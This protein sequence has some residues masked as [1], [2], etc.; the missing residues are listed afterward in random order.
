MCPDLRRELLMNNEM[1]SGPRSTWHALAA[2]WLLICL[3][4]LPSTITH[5]YAADLPE[6]QVKWMV[7]FLEKTSFDAVGLDEGYG[8]LVLWEQAVP[9]KLHFSVGE[10][11]VAD[12]E[13]REWAEE[14]VWRV[15]RAIGSDGAIKLVGTPYT[16][17]AD[18]LIIST[19]KMEYL[20]SVDLHQYLKERFEL[21]KAKIELVLEKME[22]VHY[23]ELSNW[24]LAAFDKGVSGHKKLKGFIGVIHPDKGIFKSTFSRVFAISLGY[25]SGSVVKLKKEISLKSVHTYTDT[26]YV[27]GA[28]EILLRFLYNS[29][30]RSGM[31]REIVVEAFRKWIL[32]DYFKTHFEVKTRGSPK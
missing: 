18:I 4:V 10:A 1:K 17:E 20:S 28:D 8:R 15:E 3:L 27:T 5:M 26:G 11:L 29:N 32:S 7:E 31:S 30:V 23:G 12:Q 22:E 16:F 6:N 9:V 2:I 13:T 25:G 24:Y 19:D 21:P 14:A